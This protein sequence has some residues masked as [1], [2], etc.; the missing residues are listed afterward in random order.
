MHPSVGALLSWRYCQLLTALPRR[1]TGERGMGTW[2]L[3]G[4][5][6]IVLGV[7]PGK[8]GDPA[9]C[10]FIPKRASYMRPCVPSPAEAAGWERLARLLHEEAPTGGLGAAPETAF[11]TLDC[12]MVRWWWG[13]RVV[14]GSEGGGGVQRVKLS[15]GGGSTWRM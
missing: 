13:A 4:A 3:A 9:L 10:L 6:W 7:E 14:V 1:T 8:C 2:G 15:A 11:G 12:L 5:C